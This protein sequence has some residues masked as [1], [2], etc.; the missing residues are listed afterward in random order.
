MPDW[1]TDWLT[2]WLTV[3]LTD[4]LTNRG[5]QFSISLLKSYLRARRFSE[6]TFRPSR[7]TNQEK[8]R[9]FATFL[10]LHAIVSSFFWLD[11]SALLFNCP[12][13]L[14]SKLLSIALCIL[15]GRERR[16]RQPEGHWRLFAPWFQGPEHCDPMC[17]VLPPF[18]CSFIYLFCLR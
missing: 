2:R 7:P 9:W 15:P 14:A 8:T 11:F 18:F 1:L 10:T 13:S 5:L 6:P 17:H 12:G 4:W 16:P 3:W